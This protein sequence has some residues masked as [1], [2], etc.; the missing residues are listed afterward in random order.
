MERSAHL[1]YTQSLSVS[2]SLGGPAV[3]RKYPV[4]LLYPPV[5]VRQAASDHLVHLQVR[6]RHNSPLPQLLSAHRDLL[7]LVVRPPGQGDPDGAAA[8]LPVE[9][10]HH[11][12][13]GRSPALLQRLVGFVYQILEFL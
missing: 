10:D 4:A 5:P 1:Q 3:D 8:E 2:D 11:D 13:V 12:L 9:D 6:Q 7:A